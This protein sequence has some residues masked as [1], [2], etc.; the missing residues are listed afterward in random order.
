MNKIRTGEGFKNTIVRYRIGLLV[1][2]LFSLLGVAY[3]AGGSAASFSVGAEAESGVLVGPVGPGETAGASGSA[4]VAFG[5]VAN[6]TPTP[7]PI[8]MPRPPAPSWAKLYIRPGSLKLPRNQAF[9]LEIHTNTGM[10]AIKGVKADIGYPSTKVDFVSIDAAGSGFATDVMSSGGSGL[11]SIERR[12]DQ[13]VTGDTLV[14]KIMLRTKSAAAV[15]NIDFITGS[16]LYDATSGANIIGGA[17]GSTL[18][19]NLIITREISSGT[20]PVVPL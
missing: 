16:A 6:P 15:T 20:P 12:N 3:L 2:G 18:G 14:A 1:V 13:P 19:T 4:A 9:V 11:V 10:Q 17:L 5:V 7:P 8:P